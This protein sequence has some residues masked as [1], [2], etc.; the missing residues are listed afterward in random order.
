MAPPIRRPENEPEKSALSRAGGRDSG[1]DESRRIQHRAHRHDARR[2]HRRADALSIRRSSS[3][4]KNQSDS[5]ATRTK[6]A[7][8]GKIIVHG[9][10]AVS[11]E[12][13]DLQI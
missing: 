13:P 3:M 2:F 7:H 12:K 10:P 1:P 9:R 8:V 5:P 11:P 4:G 6:T